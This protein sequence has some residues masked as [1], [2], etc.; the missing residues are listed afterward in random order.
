MATGGQR[1]VP[2]RLRG[3]MNPVRAGAIALLIITVATWLA[4]TKELPWRDPF[5]FHAVFQTSNNLRLDSPV[6]IA[7]VNV[8]E[9]V[10]VE[11]K[12]GTDL[13]E[14]TMEVEEQGLPIH[15]DAN[16][17]IRSRIFL[18]GNF[19]VELSPGT[20]SADKVDDGDTIPVTQTSTPVQLDQLLTALQTN[21]REA[22]QDLLKGLGGGLMSKPSAQED[23]DQ[24]KDVKGETTAKSLNDS[25]TFAPD[26]L[27]GSADVNEALLGTEPRDLSKLI[28]GLEKVATALSTNEEQLKSLITNFNRFFAVFAAEQ[29]SLTEA[30]EL[31]G[32]TLEN[33]NASLVSLNAAIPDLQG[34]ARE[35]TPGVAQTQRTIAAFSPWISQ[36]DRLFSRAEAGGLLNDLQPAMRY[37]ASVVDDSFDLLGETN[38]TSR[39][40]NEVILPAGQTV[41]QDGGS[42]TGVPAI[43]EFW[44]TMVGFASDAQGFDGNGS[45]TRTATGGGDILVRTGK[46]S[47][48]PRNRDVLYGHALVPPLGTRPKRPARKPAY[49]TKRDCYK[50]SIPQLNGPAAAAGPPDRIGK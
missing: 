40:F 1:V 44:Y 8:G 3:R 17:K 19:F 47:N 39:C 20:P 41:L 33:A 28:A 26:A 22:L 4:F 38:L 34:F 5:Q 13:V 12:E 14:V 10:G 16:L 35:F 18:E 2:R 37:F 42:T 11:R 50:N 31:L 45:Y 6:R 36:A 7:G 49:N 25:I 23:A 21:D 15:E 32:P 29:N 24:D 48:R 46:L 27:K 9:V 43:K 30:V